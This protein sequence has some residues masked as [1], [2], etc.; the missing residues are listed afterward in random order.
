MGATSDPLK[1]NGTAV[2]MR[3]LAE[4]GM[5]FLGHVYC[6]WSLT[7]AGVPKYMLVCRSCSSFAWLNRVED[8]ETGRGYW[9]LRLPELSGPPPCKV[10][11]YPCV[12]KADR[13][14]FGQ[15]V[16]RVHIPPDSVGRHVR[17][18]P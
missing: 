8:E 14:I 5:S 2:R 11:L 1:G 16:V 15:G 13:R 12:H 3:D 10:D 9:V 17:P 7:E 4:R 18:M 6:V